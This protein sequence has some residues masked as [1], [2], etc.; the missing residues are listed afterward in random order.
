MGR[1]VI[2]VAGRTVPVS[3]LDKV[4]YPGG[5]FTKGQVLEYYSKIAAVMLPHLKN[6]PV[7]L[8]RFPDGVFRQSFYEKN[9]PAFTPGWI[10]TFPVPRSKGGIIKYI[11]INDLPTI[12]WVANLASL[13]LHPFLHRAPKINVPTHIVFDLDPGEGVD[14]LACAEVALLVRDLLAKLKLKCFA[15][16]SGSKGIQ[17]Y[18]PLNTTVT[19]N[20]TA[21]FAR[22]LA[23]LLARQYPARVVSEMS[24]ALR[25]GKVFIDWSQNNRSKTTVG[26]YSLR[27]KRERP[28][29]SMPVDWKELA[30]A[31]RGRNIESLL[32]SPDAALARVKNR[33]DVFWPMLKLKQHLPQKF[34]NS[35]APHSSHES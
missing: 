14:I 27:A 30:Q 21:A 18:V 34:Q 16:V 17:I 33:G 19:Y 22:S 6:R 1:S 20:Q 4:L 25:V 5:K 7:T 31:I 10:K 9:A 29:V 12:L 23:E 28:F 32:F 15:K 11:L 3:N 26:V 35:S 24:K 8:V 13:E 2:K